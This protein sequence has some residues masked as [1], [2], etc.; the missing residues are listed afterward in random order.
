MRLVWSINGCIIRQYACCPLVPASKIT[1]RSSTLRSWCKPVVS[2]CWLCSALELTLHAGASV[3]GQLA[4]AAL[5]DDPAEA[6]QGPA[7]EPGDSVREVGAAPGDASGKLP[8]P[9]RAAPGGSCNAA[10]ESPSEASAGGASGKALELGVRA[11]RA[12]PEGAQGPPQA[13]KQALEEPSAPAAPSRAPSARPAGEAGRRDG[14]APGGTGASEGSGLRLGFLDPLGMLE[15]VTDVFSRRVHASASPTTLSPDPKREPPAAPVDAPP[16]AGPSGAAGSRGSR[17]TVAR[18]SSDLLRAGA[19]GGGAGAGAPPRL[20]LAVDLS[21]GRHAADG[22]EGA[23]QAPASAL[24][25]LDLALDPSPDRQAPFAADASGEA[26]GV[27]A[28]APLP[29]PELIAELPPAPDRATPS[30]VVSGGDTGEPRQDAESPADGAATGGFLG[31]PVQVGTPGGSERGTPVPGPARKLQPEPDA[32]GARSPAVTIRRAQLLTYSPA[33][34]EA[35]LS[36]IIRS[37]RS[38]LLSMSAERLWT[39][40]TPPHR[41][42]VAGKRSQASPELWERAGAPRRRPPRPWASATR[43]RR[44]ASR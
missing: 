4:T 19:E 18:P 13:P 3:G 38:I 12:G 40:V 8:G 37:P 23:Q 44:S 14:G 35:S 15:K 17:E 1:R 27:R 36:T 28:S 31:S 33:W 30:V 34:Q 2:R 26:P 24:Q 29:L 5:A 42:Q 41:Q 7:A 39:F 6:G 43:T 32:S 9:S 22:G 16:Y 10:E 21:A 20:D 11:S 25:R